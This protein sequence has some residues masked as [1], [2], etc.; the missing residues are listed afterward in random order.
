MA[1]VLRDLK[2]SFGLHGHTYALLTLTHGHTCTKKCE[3]LLENNNDTLCSCVLI[4]E[5]LILLT[6]PHWSYFIDIN[7][8]ERN[9]TYEVCDEAKATLRWNLI[10]NCVRYRRVGWYPRGQTPPLRR[11][12]GDDGGGVVRVGL[13]GEECVCGGAVMGM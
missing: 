7:G 5:C 4:N 13:G 1:P 9:F 8:K 11:K 12:G 6:K 3:N 10:E 2:L